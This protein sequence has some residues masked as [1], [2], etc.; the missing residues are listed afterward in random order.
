MMQFSSIAY[1]PKFKS[2]QVTIVVVCI[3]VGILTAWNALKFVP[4]MPYPLPI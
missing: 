2:K 4:Y 3:E 1:V